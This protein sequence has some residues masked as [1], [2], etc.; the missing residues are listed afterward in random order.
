MQT[1]PLNK[2]YVET[3]KINELIGKTYDN[4]LKNLRTNIEESIEKQS[5]IRIETK[6]YKR[7]LLK[8]EMYNVI[9]EWYNNTYND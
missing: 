6:C 9:F 5:C 4:N 3:I 7:N 2:I 1:H 8:K